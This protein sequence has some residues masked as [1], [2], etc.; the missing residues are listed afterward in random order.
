MV[1]VPSFQHQDSFLLYNDSDVLNEYDAE[2]FRDGSS[3][4]DCNNSEP[5]SSQDKALSSEPEPTDSMSYKDNAKLT[6][7]REVKRV[8]VV[9]RAD[10]INSL[11]YEARKPENGDLIPTVDIEGWNDI[12]FTTRSEWKISSSQLEM[13]S[14]W[15]K[16]RKSMGHFISH[17]HRFLRSCTMV[18]EADMITSGFYSK[19]SVIKDE[20][21]ISDFTVTTV[22]DDESSDQ[23]NL[24][25]EANAVVKYFKAPHQSSTSQ[26]RKHE[27]SH[28]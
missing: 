17:S 13:E 16:Q 11:P 9:E 10:F 24:K 15:R 28:E 2:L 5:N 25:G 21:V 23:A 7:A 27:S 18:D 12:H 4:M 19:D 14:S 8:E 1:R 6:P 26:S 20:V 3:I 22:D